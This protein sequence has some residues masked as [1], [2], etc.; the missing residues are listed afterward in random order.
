MTKEKILSVYEN[1]G[2]DAACLML[3]EEGYTIT[4]YEAMKSRIIEEAQNDNW[5]MV[6]H[7]AKI[8]EQEEA[9]YYI[10]DHSMGTLEE[11][12][13]ITDIQDLIDLL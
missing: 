6:A 9:E 11:P 5:F 13:P 4:S 10:Y 1:E 7:L 2:L 8:L 12:T 3:E